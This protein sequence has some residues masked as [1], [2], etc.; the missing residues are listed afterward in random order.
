MT[1]YFSGLA[2]DLVKA[3]LN[4]LSSDNSLDDYLTARI[5]AAVEEIEGT[6]IKLQDKQEDLLLVVDYTVWAY[7]NRD[8]NIGM[9]E[10]LRL[11]RRERWLREVRER[12]S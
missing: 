2:L 5:G 10:W 4:R 1:A 8:A 12:D 6:G 7:Q 3:R 9:P 11:R